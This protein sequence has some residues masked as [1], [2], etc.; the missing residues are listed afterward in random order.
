V[1]VAVSTV[2][3]PAR[4]TYRECNWLYLDGIRDEALQEATLRDALEHG[5]NVFCIPGVSIQADAQG[6]LGPAGTE[7]H[8]KL[9]RKLAGRAFLLPFGPISVQWP[10]HAHPDEALREKTFAEALRWYARHMQ[11]L[12]V[13]FKDFALYLQDEPGLMGRDANF[14]A[15][16]ARVK[17]FK[18][19]EPRLQLYANPAGGARADLLRPLEDLIDVWAPDLHLVREQPE[20]LSEIFRH[21]KQWWHYE[22]PADQRTLDPLGFYRVKPWVAFQMGMTGGGYWVYSAADYWS[23]DGTGGGE[24][25]SVYPTDRGPVT[26]KRWE[27]SREGIQDF[28]LLRLL[29][30]A[31]E[32]APAAARQRTLALEDQAVG[33]VTRGQEK[34]TDIS[35]HVRPYTPDFETWMRYRRDLIRAA[36]ELTRR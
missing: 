14:E 28:E 19:A 5:M 34:V 6:D 27:A 13:D 23:A 15:W 29:R 12:G 11:S 3:L 30:A 17:Q 4:F 22:A 21:G 31:A 24:Y 32:S 35:R 10:P 20:E 16:V 9:V 18:A 1:A 25:G 33:F 2:R 36:E 8:D 26:T 7:A